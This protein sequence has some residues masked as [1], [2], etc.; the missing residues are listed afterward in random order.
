MDGRKITEIE[1]AG[2]YALAGGGN[3]DE[4][5][6]VSAAGDLIFSFHCQESNANFTGVWDM[7]TRRWQVLAG[8]G[9]KSGGAFFNNTQGG[10]AS[11]AIVSD[12]M[13]L[14]LSY[15][16]ITAWRSGTEGGD[17]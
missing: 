15:N 9:D 1:Q 17:R 6:I 8:P 5:M 11:A 13:L 10:G 7:K 16:R 14:H 3:T 4:N 2:Y 12:G